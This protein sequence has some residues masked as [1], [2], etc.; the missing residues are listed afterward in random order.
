MIEAKA[1]VTMPDM[2]ISSD[3]LEFDDVKCGECRVITVQLHNHQHVRCDWN[4][5]PTDKDRKKVHVHKVKKNVQTIFTTH[6]RNTTGN[7]CFHRSSIFLSTARGVPQSLVPSPFRED[8]PVSGPKVLFG[9]L[10]SLVPSFF[11][12]VPQSLVPGP[13]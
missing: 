5:H 10:P 2:Q 12:G 4:S 11:G 1:N 8:T 3:V 7:E 13:F 6:V 9:V